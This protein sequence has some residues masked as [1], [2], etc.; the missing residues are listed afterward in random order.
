MANLLK[1]LAEIEQWHLDQKSSLHKY[2]AD[3]INRAS[4]L[5]KH[6][7][8]IIEE[9]ERD[10]TTHKQLITELELELE[11]NKASPDLH[12]TRTNMSKPT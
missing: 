6:E 11:D 7:Y 9:Q 1:D 12:P 3:I 10:I 8:S 2:R 4:T 5:L